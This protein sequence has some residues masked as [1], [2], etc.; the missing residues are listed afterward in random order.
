MNVENTLTKEELVAAEKFHYVIDRNMK[1]F[2]K[3][4]VPSR[5]GMNPSVGEELNGKVL[6]HTK[7]ISAAA[8]QVV[9]Y[10]GLTIFHQLV[11]HNY[12]E[13]VEI[14][15]K[16][17][18]D[19]NVRGA[20]GKGDYADSHKGV[21]P[22]HLACHSG[23]YEMVKLLLKY[24]A[25]TTICDDRGRNCFHFLASDYYRYV[26]DYSD[27]LEENAIEQR[28]EIAKLL[29]SDISKSY[30][31]KCDIY[32]CDINQRDIDGI[33]PLHRLM[34]NGTKLYTVAFVDMF[35]EM[36]ADAAIADENGNTALMTAVLKEHVA[37]VERLAKYPEMVNAQNNAGDTALHKVFEKGN[38]NGAIG[39]I[40]VEAGADINIKNNAGVTAAEFVNKQDSDYYWDLVRKCVFKKALR[41]EDYFEII[42]RFGRD[43]WG[44]KFDDY[45][46]FIRGIARA[47]LKKI[48]KDDD[49]ELVYVIKLLKILIER[50]NGCEALQ[51]LHEEG[52]PFDM[53]ICDRSQITTIR[54]IC[55]EEAWN[56]IEVIPKLIE[57]GVDLDEALANGRTPAGLVASRI[58]RPGVGG[59]VHEGVAMVYDYLGKDAME[60]LDNEGKAAI[61]LAVEHNCHTLVEK[62]I[63]KGVDINLTT[64]APSDAGNTPLHIACIYHNAK[65]ARMLVEAGANDSLVNVEEETPAHCLFSDY[66]RYDSKTC[67]EIMEMLTNIDTPK[68]DTGETPL[69]LLQKKNRVGVREITELLLSKGANV[70]HSDNKGNTPLLIHAD[71]CCDRDVVK[72]MLKA[73]ADINARNEDGNSLLHYV[74]EHGDCEL[75]RLLIKKGADYNAIN[76]K[77]ETPASMAVKKGYDVVLELM[78]DIR[79]YNEDE[80]N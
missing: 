40:L 18:V 33:T 44:H 20:E 57:L 23:N 78:T 59:H 31:D 24:G 27:A 39:Y 37:A 55:I 13:A 54:D 50:H 47:L 66:N 2:H 70:N 71:Y 22:L 14:L 26:C 74:I 67:Y 53:P 7:N 36:G 52:Y 79:F 25:D 68:A 10:Y 35:L 29:K 62:M 6:E 58:I 48:D 21:T 51:I 16:K 49:T 12:Y 5:L 60:T 34:Q 72:M 19:P 77:G 64:D 45:N 9:G 80:D 8:A 38:W 46:G 3:W 1:L 11:C 73:G 41:I 15:L 43:W 32:K 30:I 69:I 76:H 28:V 42:D 63:G 75:A 56:H 65:I 61:H 4:W 17:G